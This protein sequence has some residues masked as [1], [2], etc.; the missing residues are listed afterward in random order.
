MSTELIHIFE[1][2][3]FLVALAAFYISPFE[4]SVNEDEDDE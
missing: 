3:L 4:W 1:V 2:S